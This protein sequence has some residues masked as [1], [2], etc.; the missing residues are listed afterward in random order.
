[1]ELYSHDS[2]MIVIVL[3]SMAT[4]LMRVGGLMLAGC[5]P[6]GGR[7][8]RVL[9]AL[10]GTIL[11]SLAAP[12]FFNEGVIGFAGG[13]VTVAVA[14]KTKNVFLAMFMGMLVVALGRQAGF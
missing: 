3:A 2:A 10:P 11:I 9:N 5:L 1:M 6:S 8:G 12:G 14:F 13:I 4:Y 7:I